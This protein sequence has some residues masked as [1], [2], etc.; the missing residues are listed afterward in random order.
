MPMFEFE[1][2]IFWYFYLYPL[3]HVENYVCL[4]HGVQV[5]GATWRTVMRI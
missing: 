3:V 4:S 1:S 5:G 2:I